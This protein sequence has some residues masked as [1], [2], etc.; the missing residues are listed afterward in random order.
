MFSG[1]VPPRSITQRGGSGFQ[2]AAVRTPGPAVFSTLRFFRCSQ[3]DSRCFPSQPLLHSG[4]FQFA[5][6]VRGSPARCARIL[7]TDS[8]GGANRLA[9]ETPISFPDIAQRPVHR[10][11]YEISLVARLA[12]DHSQ[13][14]RKT[15][16]RSGFVLVAKIRDQR[17]AG[18]LHELFLA[19]V[20]FCRFVPSGRACAYK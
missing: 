10:F 20:P 4:A 18:A 14:S 6:R 12:F 15:G 3:S 13:E 17:K 7:Q 16:I 2:A 9:V 19:P 8:L 5:E 1:S 11:L